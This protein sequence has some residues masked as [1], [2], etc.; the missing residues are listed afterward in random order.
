[1][2][3]LQ[4]QICDVY[5]GL[6]TKLGN[7]NACH[8]LVLCSIIHEYRRREVDVLGLITT[9]LE[10]GWIRSDYYVKDALAILQYATRR[11]WNVRAVQTVPDD[12][13]DNEY[14]EVVWYRAQTGF[15][16][17]TRRYVD[18]LINSQTVRY[19]V[20]KEYRIYRVEE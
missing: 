16:H 1:M 19:G 10:K 20:I 7:N 11:R 15:T 2:T 3:K 6:Q 9:S 13:G 8:F 17:F 4:E 5:N 18:T 12:L 14:T